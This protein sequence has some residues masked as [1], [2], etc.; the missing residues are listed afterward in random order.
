[1]ALDALSG[2]RVSWGATDD[3]PLA[4]AFAAARSVPL[5]R[6]PVTVDGRPRIDGALAS[7]T[8][9]DLLAGVELAVVITGSPADAAPGSVDAHW[10]AALDDELAQL[11][12]AGVRAHVLRAD[13][14]DRVALGPDPMS[15]QTA[16][17]AVRAGRRRGREL[18]ILL[19]AL[20]TSAQ[21]SG[22]V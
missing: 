4:R 18:A 14:S 21:L 3:V 1:V 16:P 17:L 7:A 6:P 8:S 9:A 5:L 2:E 11:D 13:A 10:N 19:R 12:A 20:R 15:A 22:R